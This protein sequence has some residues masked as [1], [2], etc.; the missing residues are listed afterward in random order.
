MHRIHTYTAAEAGLLVNSY[1]V[2]ADDGV[3]LVDAN[4]LQSDIDALDARLTALRKPLL[5]V[6]V[7]HAHPDHFNG[8]PTLAADDV[9]VFA[10]KDVADTIAAIADAKR[11]QWQPVY[12]A[13]WPATHRVPDSLLTDGESVDLGGLRFTLHAVGAAE[14]HADSYLTLGDTAFIGDLAFHGTHPYTADGHTGAWLAALDGLADRLAGHTLRPGHGAPG[15]V[16]MLADQRRYLMMYREVVRRLAAGAPAL[17]DG[18][19]AELTDVMTAFLPDAP[20][21][22]MIALGADAVAAELA[23]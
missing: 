23:G 21:S 8:L 13:E 18:Q 20:L 19:K 3:V 16:R 12:G 5:G 22:W 4:L 11:E 15:D 17:T 9:P 6:F 14:S 7:T 2:E 10:A 1:L